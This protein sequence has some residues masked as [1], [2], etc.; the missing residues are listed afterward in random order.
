MV[1]Q[2]FISCNRGKYIF[3]F[4]IRSNSKKGSNGIISKNVI[5]HI[6]KKYCIGWSVD[7]NIKIFESTNVEKSDFRVWPLYLY[8]QKNEKRRMCRKSWK[9]METLWI[10]IYGLLTSALSGG[11]W[12]WSK[13]AFK[14]LSD[15]WRK[16]K[17]I[18]ARTYYIYLED[19]KI[20]IFGVQS[21]K[22]LWE[23]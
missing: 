1:S 2:K 17:Y 18:F 22:T 12:T 20:Y 11:T 15:F 6:K 21:Q 9:F 14:R 16:N 19:Q 23:L 3:T 5:T 10:Y 4:F 13:A 7:L 8:P